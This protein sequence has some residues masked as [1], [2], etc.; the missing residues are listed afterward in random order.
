[1][2]MSDGLLLLVIK[3]KYIYKDLW[4]PYFTTVIFFTIIAL[5]IAA[6]YK[7]ADWKNWKLYYPTILFY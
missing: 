6:A 7:F 5:W 1:M 2:D 3:H 4:K